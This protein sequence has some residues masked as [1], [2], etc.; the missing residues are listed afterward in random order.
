M[1]LLRQ[2][3]QFYI[4][5]L[6][7]ILESSGLQRAKVT[8]FLN[9]ATCSLLP[10]LSLFLPCSFPQ[11]IF[12][13]PD[14]SKI[15]ELSLTL[16]FHLHSFILSVPLRGILPCC[17]YIACLN[18]C[19]KSWSKIPWPSQPM[20]FACKFKLVWTLFHHKK[21]EGII[22][23]GKEGLEAGVSDSWSYCFS[24][25]E[26]VNTGAQ[27]TFPFSS[28][29][30]TVPPTVQVSLS[31]FINLI[32]SLTNIPGGLS[33]KWFYNLSSWHSVLN[34]TQTKWFSV[35]WGLFPAYLL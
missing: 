5:H 15:L 26:A 4:Q 31:I 13:D 27:L 7:F 23:H 17:I 33:S 24:K 2:I 1:L 3:L 29:H 18:M 8:T 30:R 32:G 9:S 12:S 22:H 10:G 14:I 16:R 19:L 21:F 20:P 25:Q 6:G 34:T 28:A 11:Q 35:R